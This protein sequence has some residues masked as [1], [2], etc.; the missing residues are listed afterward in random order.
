MQPDQNHGIHNNT[1]KPDGLRED[2]Q[3]Q[4]L[5]LLS[6]LGLDD[7]TNHQPIRYKTDMAIHTLR[8]TRMLTISGLPNG[9]HLE[10]IS[11]LKYKK[12]D[13]G[14]APEH[15]WKGEC[16]HKRVTVLVR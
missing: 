6:N 15:P 1:T 7:L 11:G 3:H 8:D 5:R 4:L 12:R 16:A 13:K 10:G 14:N 2:T 9:L